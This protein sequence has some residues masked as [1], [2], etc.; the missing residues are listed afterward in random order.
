MQRREPDVAGWILWLGVGL[1]VIPALFLIAVQIRLPFQLNLNEGWNA[2]HA[3]F[4]RNGSVL[5]PKEIDWWVSNYPPVSFWLSAA[6]APLAGSSNLAG[7]IANVGGVALLS[8]AVGWMLSHRLGRS[9][10]YLGGAFSFFYF[11]FVLSGYVAVNDPQMTGLGLVFLGFCFSCLAPHTG[12]NVFAGAALM[13]AGCGVKHNLVTVL[14]VAG[15]H[16]WLTDRRRAFTW[17]WQVAALG[18]LGLGFCHLLYGQA[19][20]GNLISKRGYSFDSMKQLVRVL[21]QTAA[22]PLG[23]ALVYCLRCPLPLR[24]DYLIPGMLIGGLAGTAFAGGKCC[25]ECLL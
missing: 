13:A 2:Y 6:L 16:L 1:W 17:S 23:L 15:L 18:F 11:A 25:S 19:F 14:L 22:V 5:Y 20:W 12:R 24:K 10:G 4:V 7:R 9:W 3:T 8:L 21:L